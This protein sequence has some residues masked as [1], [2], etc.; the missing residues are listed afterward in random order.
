MDAFEIWRAEV[1]VFFQ[2][3][4]L[5]NAIFFFFFIPTIQ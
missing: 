2:T 3:I 1:A 5:P 4:G